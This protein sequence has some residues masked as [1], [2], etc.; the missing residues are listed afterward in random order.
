MAILPNP[1]TWLSDEE[2]TADKLNA[3]LRESYR[4]L[5]NPPRACVYN[6][7][8]QQIRSETEDLADV[9]GGTL[10]LQWNQVRY[11][12]DNMTRFNEG[13]DHLYRLYINT[14]GWWEVVLHVDWQQKAG[15]GN[16]AN[17]YAAIKL[18]NT[19]GAS[20]GTPQ[21]IGCDQINAKDDDSY[22]NNQGCGQINHVSI[23][24]Y[25]SAGSYLEAVVRN[26][27]TTTLWTTPSDGT[28]GPHLTFFAAHWL[29][30]G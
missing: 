19:T 6:D 7:P 2:V 24:R 9:N 29:G 18:N 13:G 22:F 26:T 4:F 1:R 16:A 20:F 10:R 11:D 17:R 12:T 21:V 28:H 3:D 15:A 23:H 25:L 14:S 5:L 27:S 30:A 8:G